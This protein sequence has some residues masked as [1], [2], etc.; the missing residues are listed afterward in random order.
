MTRRALPEPVLRRARRRGGGRARARAPRGPAGS[1]PGARRRRPRRRRHARVRRRLLRRARGG[2]A[3]DPARRGSTSSHP[4]CSSAGRRSARAATATRA[5]CSRAKLGRRGMPVVAAMTPDSPG[6]LAA[7]G[8]AYIVPTGSNVAGHARG[9]AGRGLARDRGSAAGEPIGARRREGYLP[10]GLRANALADRT[11]AA[12]RGRSAAGEARRRR[13]HRGRAERRPRRRRPPPV[14]D[15]T[16]VRLA[17]VTEAGCVP[18]GNPDRLPTRHANVWLRYPIAGV[19]SLAADEYESVHAG[20]DTTAANAD[21]NR[22]VPLD[23]ARELERDGAIATPARRLLHDDAASTRRSPRRRKF[24]QEIAAELREAKVGGRDPHRHL[25]HRHALR[26][27]AGEGVRT[28]GHPDR[29]RD[30]AAD[31]RT[32]GGGEPHPAGRRDHATRRATRRSP[33]DDELA[34]RTRARAA[35]ARDARDRGRAAR[36]CGRS[37]RDAARRRD[38]GVVRARAR[39]RPGAVRLEAVAGA[40]AARAARPPLCARYDEAVA[41]P[42]NQVFVG[43]L[44]A[45]TL[46]DASARLVAA[47]RR[48]RGARRPVRRRDGPRPLLRAARR[49]RP[50]RSRAA[51]GRARARAS[52][53]CSTATRWSARSPATTSDDESLTAAGAA[54]EPRDQGERRARAAAPA[55]DHRRRSASIT[56]AIGCGEEAVGDRYQRGGGNVAKAIAEQCGLARASGDRREV[57][58]RGAGARD[59][60][61]RRADRGRHRGAGRASWRAVRSASSA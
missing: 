6:V 3:R 25:R 36:P 13:A 43:A 39:A 5:A 51:R 38:V 10:R 42:P 53:R 18:Q 32:D 49:G 44:R 15:L 24:G 11:G 54:R 8:A 31:D 37:R 30:R 56:H 2:R 12:A 41:Y 55:R 14:A 22:L 46:W 33:R 57:V 7:E 52:S 21:P 28:R 16:S 19:D 60:R 59:R 23:A 34:L 1:G 26:G 47:P 4:T 35:R 40:A 45:A 61:G 48:G 29:V 20:F 58:L 50:V 9:A 17:L 27:N